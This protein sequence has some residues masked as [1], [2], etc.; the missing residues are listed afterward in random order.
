MMNETENSNEIMAFFK[1]MVD[2]DRLRIAGL[3]GVES[4]S[5]VQ[6]AERLRLQPPAVVTHLERLT[7]AGLV[8]E[9]DGRY[10]LDHRALENLAR[11]NLAGLRP[12]AKIEIFDGEAFDKKV[13]KDFMGPDG[14]F[15]ILPQQDKKF[16]SILH[17]AAHIFETGRAY[18]EKEVNDLLKQ[19]HPDT[20][21]LRRGL[22]DAGLLERSEAVNQQS[23]YRRTA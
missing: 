23:I 3:L 18:P 13:V 2:A 20:A 14:K 22:V 4:L 10:R 12:K 19:F 11:R 5:P 6:I 1:T 7:N 8:Q 15:K 16:L 21:S 17:Y 9:Q